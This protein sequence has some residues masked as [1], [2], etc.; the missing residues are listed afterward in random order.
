MPTG[1]IRE[2]IKGKKY[3]LIIE[4]G[5]DPKTGRRK[6]VYRVC[7]GRKPDAE[8]ELANIIR[9]LEQ[10]TYIEPS[11]TT[12]AEYLRYWLDAYG[13]NLAPSTFASYNRIVNTHIIP[14]LGGIELARLQPLQIQTYYSEKLKGG[15]ADGTGG[16]SPRTVQYHHTVLRE[17]LQHA[18]K[19]QMLSRNP[20]DATEPPKPSKAEIHPLTPDE[21]AKLLTVADG[22]RDKW[23]FMFAAYTG[24]REG[25]ILALTWSAVDY[26]GKKPYARVKQTVGYINGQGFVYRPLGKTKKSRREIALLDMAVYALRQQKKLQI[27]ERLSAPPGEFEETDLIFTTDRGKPVDPSGLT[28]R[29]KTLAKKAG[30]PNIRFHDLRH[31]YATLMLTLGIHP[32]IVQEILG[33]ETIGITMDTYS[34]V[35]KG[36]QQEAISKANEYLAGKNGGKMAGNEKSHP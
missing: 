6:R 7:N 25:E 10:G 12:V 19:W 16:L 21:L 11:K 22:H 32:K 31:T 36:M 29:F 2:L 30:F 33:H 3:E 24:M 20:A 34:H 15:R 9:E 5:R 13:V 8:R 17:A 14:S 1:R 18:V 27:A 28:R 26:E 23:L 35:L 4:A